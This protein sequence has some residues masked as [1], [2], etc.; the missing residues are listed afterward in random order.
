M[1]LAIGM[2]HDHHQIAGTKTA[3]ARGLV[4]KERD[5]LDDALECIH[6]GRDRTV[7][8]VVTFAKCT[9]WTARRKIG[10]LQTCNWL[11]IVAPLGENLSKFLPYGLR[12]IANKGQWRLRK[13]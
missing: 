13:L 9:R 12:T 4:T 7:C 11:G 3:A 5:L 1:R 8:D 2:S 10:A 6:H